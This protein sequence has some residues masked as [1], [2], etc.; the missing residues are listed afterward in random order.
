MVVLCTGLTMFLSGLLL[1]VS[2]AS[3]SDVVRPG[4]L[5]SSEGKVIII[6]DMVNVRYDLRGLAGI[7]VLSVGAWQLLLTLSAG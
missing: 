7:F 5:V 1:L 3:S 4:A 6:E 2:L